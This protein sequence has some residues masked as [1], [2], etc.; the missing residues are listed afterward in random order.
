L[1]VTGLGLLE[2]IAQSRNIPFIWADALHPELHCYGVVY[3]VTPNFE[4]LAASGM[5]FSRAPL[6]VRM[7]GK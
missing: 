5:L 6:I 1:A 7:L 2:C 3:A 4:R